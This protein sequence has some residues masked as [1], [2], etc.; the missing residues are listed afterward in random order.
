LATCWPGSAGLSQENGPPMSTPVLTFH[1]LGR[2][3]RLGNQLWEI[4]AVIGIARRNGCRF[5][6]PRWEYARCFE[7]ELPQVESPRFE[8]VVRAP[9][10][11]YQ[12]VRV[13]RDTSLEG[14]FQNLRYFRHCDD[15]VRRWFAPRPGLLDDLRRRYR[16]ALEGETCSVHVRR[17][18]YLTEPNLVKLPMDY[19]RR[20]M[21]QFD[22][23]TRFLVFSDDPAWCRERFRGP[24]AAVM[25]RQDHDLLDL[26]LM[27]LCRGH[28]I[29]NSTFSWWAAWLDP[30]PDKRVIAPIPWVVPSYP[31][32]DT[33]QM[34][35]R[36]W[37]RI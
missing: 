33:V 1:Q 11:T 14:G 20:A 28:I 12:E 2:Y 22:G 27:S 15:E 8:T 21:S 3:G 5:V 31:G 32:G 4:A 16:E 17:T 30:R 37:L 23:R 10:F 29:A 19:Y 34:C 35:P 24:N 25:P 36:E 9:C 13:V 18:D 26:F 7:T 6:L